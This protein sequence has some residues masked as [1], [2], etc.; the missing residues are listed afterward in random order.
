MLKFL[1]II[2]YYLLYLHLI[3]T[4]LISISPTI[5]VLSTSGIPFDIPTSI[6]TELGLIHSPLIKCLYPTAETTMSA[7]Y[8]NYLKN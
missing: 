7:Y 3:I 5:L 8:K 1:F 6:T 2:Y 4:S